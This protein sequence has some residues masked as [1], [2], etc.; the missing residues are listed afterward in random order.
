ME[1]IKLEC[2]YIGKLKPGYEYKFLKH[3]KFVRI[4]G[5]HPNKPPIIY[6]YTEGQLIFFGGTDP[7]APA[8][9]MPQSMV[10]VNFPESA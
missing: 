1:P 2:T 3:D 8:A 6:V 7:E 9:A 5:C 4:V 10:M